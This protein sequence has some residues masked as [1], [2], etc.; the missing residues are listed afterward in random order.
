ML[1]HQLNIIPAHTEHAQGLDRPEITTS[2]LSDELTE[3]VNPSVNAGS[4]GLQSCLHLV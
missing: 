2:E 3:Q 1:F 4:G